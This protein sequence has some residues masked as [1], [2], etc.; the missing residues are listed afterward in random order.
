M[1]ICSGWIFTV[2]PNMFGSG[3]HARQSRRL[4]ETSVF[5]QMYQK[6]SGKLGN[7]S[8]KLVRQSGRQT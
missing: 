5:P 1:I 6:M 4:P 7:G 3:G 8:D 2:K